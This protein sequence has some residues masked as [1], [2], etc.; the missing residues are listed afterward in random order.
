MGK[1]RDERDVGGRRGAGRGG[2][3]G[4]WVLSLEPL[5]RNKRKK[6]GTSERKE[7]KRRNR[8][9]GSEEG[10]LAGT[11]CENLAWY[12]REDRAVPRT[13]ADTTE[14]FFPFCI[15]GTPPHINSFHRGL[16]NN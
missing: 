15:Y 14:T 1:A 2:A 13:D 9:R 16:R 6:G 8:K 10:R 12:T 11:V 5:K 3:G 4:L 7:E